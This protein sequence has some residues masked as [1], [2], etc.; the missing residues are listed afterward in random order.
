MQQ[1]GRGGSITAPLGMGDMT[2]LLSGAVPTTEKLVFSIL[3]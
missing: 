3:Q 2:T 1:P